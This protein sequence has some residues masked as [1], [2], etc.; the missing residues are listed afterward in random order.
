MKKVFGVFVWFLCFMAVWKFSAFMVSASNT[1]L[2]ILGAFIAFIF[3]GIS[4]GTTF[5]TDFSKIAWWR[6][7]KNK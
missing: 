1:F 6:T 5:F 4:Y 3:G 7:K 2:V